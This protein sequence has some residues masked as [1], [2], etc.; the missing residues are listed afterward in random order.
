MG[1]LGWWLTKQ[2][3]RG[4]GVGVVEADL[5]FSSATNLINGVDPYIV[6]TSLS[7]LLT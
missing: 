1:L 3:G 2:V 7:L 4:G 5:S 6:S